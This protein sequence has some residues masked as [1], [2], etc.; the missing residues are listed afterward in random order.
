MTAI[1]APIVV[2]LFFIAIGAL[3]NTPNPSVREFF[4]MGRSATPNQYT[5]TTVGYSLQVAV[6]IYF[7][8]FGYK[9]GWD[10]VYFILS[11][12]AGFALFAWA[13]PY[14]APTL[15]TKPTM[16]AILALQAKNL[17]LVAI[18]LLVCS[19]AGLIYT[20][21][22]F[23]A[24][25]LSNVAGATGSKLSQTGT[26]WTSFALLAACTLVYASLGGARKV[27]VT[28]K[29]QLALAY[30]SLAILLWLL[31]DSI[32]AKGSDRYHVTYVGL[33][34]IFLL[35]A[36]GGPLASWFV[37][38][39]ASPV[40]TQEI[41]L[42]ISAANVVA[43]ACSLALLAGIIYHPNFGISDNSPVP[44]PFGSMF[45]EPFGWVAL[46]GFSA[47]NLLW[48]FA[49][50]TA[51]DRLGMLRQSGNDI[52]VF[53]SSIAATAV[54]SPITW[55]FG[56]FIG[57]AIDAAD[58][59]PATSTDIF[60]DFYKAIASGG[61]LSA[62]SS[63]VA[64]G[65][66]GVF[67]ICVMLST[68]DAATLAAAKLLM[69][70]R[71]GLVDRDDIKVQARSRLL[72]FSATAAIVSIIAILHMV[73]QFDV[74]VFLNGVYSWGLI[75]G[76]IMIWKLLDPKG[77]STSFAAAGLLLGAVVGAVMS[78][79]PFAIPQMISY[80][81]PSILAI[82]ACSIVAIVGAVVHRR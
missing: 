36:V 14:I 74:F 82:T 67:F 8:Y 5:D 51:Y 78:T 54:T 44:K 53:R 76:P 42:P 58:L 20:E 23:S 61:V 28:E 7:V 10:N 3:R 55:A 43:L 19:L 34:L 81:A 80:V 32:A 49:D 1:L 26:Y 27:V 57:M 16:L 13:M 41:G 40:E 66:L 18:V 56:V 11:W 62:L 79:S 77:F 4:F 30:I 25:F 64:A 37:R 71:H 12:C 46:A 75:F 29:L 47:I 45:A 52:R 9:Y 65:A 48:Q 2:L 70:D 60:G 22:F 15:R 21:L 17:R 72:F 24:Q 6:T 35:L 59:V 33:T 73:I 50:Y 38:R 39:A 31:R 69:V 68:S 63:Q